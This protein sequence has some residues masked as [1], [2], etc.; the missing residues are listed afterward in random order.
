MPQPGAIQIHPSA[1]ILAFHLSISENNRSG[2]LI[3]S[4]H[5]AVMALRTHKAALLAIVRASMD[6]LVNTIRKGKRGAH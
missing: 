1:F 5:D 3:I 6:M 2:D 4:S